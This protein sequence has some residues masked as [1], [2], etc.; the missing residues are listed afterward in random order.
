MLS[1][2]Y[3]L[4]R[5]LP[6]TIPVILGALQGLAAGLWVVVS[7]PRSY[8]GIG[9][10]LT[11]AWGLMLIVGSL[12]ILIAHLIRVHQVELPGLAFALG[13]ILTY[14]YLS[15]DQT[16]GDSPGSGPRALLLGW[17]LCFLLT[18][19]VLLVHADVKARARKD[20]HGEAADG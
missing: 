14:V 11:F 20:Q 17:L 6:W 2:P 5:L 9:L 3:P 18:R 10:A 16:I 4:Q 19:L 12:L 13:G 8:E 1:S 15:W 7:P